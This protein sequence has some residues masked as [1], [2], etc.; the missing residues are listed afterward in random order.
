MDVEESVIRVRRRVEGKQA[1]EKRAEG[2]ERLVF[3]IM[4]GIMEAEARGAGCG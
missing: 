4:V 1:R 2:G 3:R